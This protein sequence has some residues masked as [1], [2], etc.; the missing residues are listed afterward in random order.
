M[1]QIL[2]I[3]QATHLIH[4]PCD[5]GAWMSSELHLILNILLLLDNRSLLL[6]ATTTRSLLLRRLFARHA[7]LLGATGLLLQRLFH[8][9]L[10]I[11][12]GLGVNILL[13]LRFAF[14]RSLGLLGGRCRLAVTSCSGRRGGQCSTRLDSGNVS[15]VLLLEADQQLPARGG[16]AAKR[17]GSGLVTRSEAV[18]PGVGTGR[19]YDPGGSLLEPSADSAARAFTVADGVNQHQRPQ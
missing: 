1:T 4:L 7:L 5:P 18:M 13:N 2:L 11:C 19:Y 10:T 15:L 17:N 9:D 6:L 14:A 3:D 16:R 12:L 8:L